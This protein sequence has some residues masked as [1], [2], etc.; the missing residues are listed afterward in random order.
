MHV[1]FTLDVGFA[2]YQNHC[3]HNNA[4]TKECDDEDDSHYGTHKWYDVTARGY[5]ST[6]WWQHNST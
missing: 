4:H 5:R 2:S 3:H 1:G 6:C